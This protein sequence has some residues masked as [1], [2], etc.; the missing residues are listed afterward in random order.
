MACCDSEIVDEF[1]NEEAGKGT[2]KIRDAG[3]V[4]SCCLC[5]RTSEQSGN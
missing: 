4:V 2:A 5:K 1:E 3:W